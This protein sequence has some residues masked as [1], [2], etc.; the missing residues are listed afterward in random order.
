MKKALIILSLFAFKSASSLEES[1]VKNEVSTIANEFLNT[2]GTQGMTIGIIN[3]STKEVFCYGNSCALPSKTVVPSNVFEIGSITKVF[4]GILFSQQILDGKMNTDDKLANY[5]EGNNGDYYSS[6]TLKQLATHSSG[7]PRLADN[8]WNCVKDP[9]NPYAGYSE[10]DLRSYLKNVKPEND[11]GK[12]YSYSNVGMGILGWV[13]SNEN[14]REYETLVKENICNKLGMK[15]TSATLSTAQ[16]SSLA[17]GY[18][19]GKEVMN[20]DFQ[21]CTSGQGSL[22]SDINDMLRFAEANIHPEK[23]AISDAIKMSQEI[24]FRD[25]RTGRPMGYGWH[26]G[27][28]D[29]SKYLE[30]TGGTAGYRSFIGIIPDREIAVVILSN[31]DKDVAETGLRV[32]RSVT[33]HS[34]L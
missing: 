5:V 23:T 34:Q 22:R 19:E 24:H 4:T 33:S 28:F 31:S 1:P 10:N 9:G 11:P 32:L 8:F 27:G 15:N 2:E 29:G 20:W 3:R 17:K 26:I 14:H 7:L 6:I 12:Y 16:R 18:S 21:N 30:H 13:I 25:Q